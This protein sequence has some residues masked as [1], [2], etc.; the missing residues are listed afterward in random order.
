MQIKTKNLTHIFDPGGFTEFKALTSVNSEIHQGEFITIIGQTG[1][2]K[3]TYIEHLNALLL[4]TDGEVIIGDRVITNSKKKIKKI[5][6]LRKKVGIVFQFAEYQLFEETILKDIIFGPIT[7]GM[8]KAKAIEKAKKYIK[9]VGMDEEF[10]SKSPFSLSGGQKR[11]I[12][13]AG[14]LAMEPDILIFDEPTAGLDPHGEIEM[15]KIFTQLYE[16]GKAIVIV[17]HNLDHALE[18][19][20]RTIL[21]KDGKIIKDGKTIDILYDKKLLEKNELEVPKLVSLV[22]KIEAKNF[23]IGRP[24]SIK[25][26]VKVVNQKRK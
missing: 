6:Q 24:V 13:L 8:E 3:T 9:L 19:S 26:F 11:R 12:A 17:T 20:Q 18:Y 21:F 1:S 23:K 4:P 2:G 25:S 22:K 5:K 10:L 16:A 14:I 7:M 15:Y